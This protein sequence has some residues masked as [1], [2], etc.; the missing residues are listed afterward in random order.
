MWTLAKSLVVIVPAFLAG[1]LAWL[2][3]PCQPQRSVV[4]PAGT[5]LLEFSPT[6]RYVLTFQREERRLT[7]WQTDTGQATFEAEIPYVIR[8][9]LPTVYAGGFYGFSTDDRQLAV[10]TGAPDEPRL[11]IVD[12]TSDNTLT[13][14]AELPPMPDKYFR[15]PRF[16][17]D[18]RFLSYSSQDDQGR[19]CAVLYDL[20]GKQEWLRVAGISGSLGP[21]TRQGKWLLYTANEI[22]LWDVAQ[23]R[24]E[25]TLPPWPPGSRM[26][27][28]PGERLSGGPSI[29]PDEQAV[30]ALY[31]HFIPPEEHI[32]LYRCDLTTRKIE[33]VWEYALPP[34]GRPLWEIGGSWA[35]RFLLINN[36]DNN[37]DLIQDL[38]DVA[39]GQVV[40]RY[41]EPIDMLENIAESLRI[42]AAEY[43]SGLAVSLGRTGEMV[44]DSERRFVVREQF[45]AETSPATTSASP[46]RQRLSVQFYSA[47]TGQLLER[48]SLHAPDPPVWGDPVLAMH[49]SEPLLAVV[50][51]QGSSSRLQFWRVPPPKPWGWIAAC[52]LAAAACSALACIAYSVAR[53]RES[54]SASPAKSRAQP[55]G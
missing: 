22:E 50:D 17:S 14:I 25:A 32:F 28:V 1:Y 29:T 34:S 8:P 2:F 24:R 4:L 49:P 51:E 5:R 41:P 55:I 13:P 33:T 11:V 45:S 53:K 48:I 27:D 42:P 31:L 26:K 44:I 10:A 18:D 39:T 47:Q 21:P 46:E 9:M 36:R 15:P 40:I 6:G 38:L 16:S 43:G 52:A 30:A 19:D 37:G 3:L 7:L 54:E 35:S 20:V 12:L 23:R